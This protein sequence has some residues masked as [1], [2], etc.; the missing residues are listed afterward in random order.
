[1]ANHC[2]LFVSMSSANNQDGDGLVRGT[3]ECVLEAELALPIPYHSHSS[4]IPNPGFYAR[5][6]VSGSESF[7]GR[8]AC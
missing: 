2:S 4:L 6:C 5:L 7:N 3:E 8:A 1:M